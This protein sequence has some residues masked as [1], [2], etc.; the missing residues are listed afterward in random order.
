MGIQFVLQFSVEMLF[1]SN[2]VANQGRIVNIFIF[3]IVIIA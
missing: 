2:N 1:C 3:V